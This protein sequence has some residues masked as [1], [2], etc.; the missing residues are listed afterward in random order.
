[1]ITAL[2]WLSLGLNLFFIGFAIKLITELVRYGRVAPFIRT[3][4]VIAEEIAG[5]FGTLPEGSV[6]VD[7]FCGDGRVLFAIAEQNPRAGFLG[8]E[9][10]TYPYLR[11]LWWKRRFPGLNIRFI[12]GNSYRQD[13]SSATH[14]Y[15]YSSHDAMDTLLPKLE[16]EAKPGTELISLDFAFSNKIAERTIPLK[17]AQ[18]GKLGQVAYVYRF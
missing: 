5:I 17:T 11:A 6:V 3:R 13:L 14:L 2:E 10:R 15:T 18:E 9:L 12:R 4:D 7:P 1:M 16:L 8:I